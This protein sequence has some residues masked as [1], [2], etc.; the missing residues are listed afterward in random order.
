MFSKF[1]NML[2]IYH[3]NF[4][5][6]HLFIYFK[7]KLEIHFKLLD[8]WG[9]ITASDRSLEWAGLPGICPEL[10]AHGRG[11]RA[12]HLAASPVS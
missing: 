1:L 2:K 12:V 11:I 10:S 4:Q 3:I 8:S 6:A 5:N 9:V 7:K